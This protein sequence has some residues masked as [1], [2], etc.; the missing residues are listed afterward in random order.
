MFANRFPYTDFN[1]VNLDWIMR[2]L[3][4]QISGL[5]ASVNGMTGDVTLTASDVGALPAD[6]ANMVNSVNGETGDVE[7]TAYDITDSRFIHTS[8]MREEYA[9][10]IA[11]T[12]V[13]YLVNMADGTS[14]CVVGSPTKDNPFI[15]IYRDSFYILPESLLTYDSL[16]NNN[17]TFGIYTDG[18]TFNPDVDGNHNTITLDGVAYPI[19][20][21]TCSSFV[22]MLCKNRAYTDSPFYELFTNPD[23]TG[24]TLADHMTEYGDNAKSPWTM[25]FMNMF[26]SWKIAENMISSGCNPQPVVHYDGG[27]VYDDF[28]ESLRDGALLFMGNETDFPNRNYGIYHVVFYFKTLDRLNQVAGTDYGCS[29]KAY[30]SGDASRGYIVHCSGSTNNTTFGMLNVLRIETLSHYLSVSTSFRKTGSVVYG[31]N[32]SANALNSSKKAKTVTG[33][34]KLVDCYIENYYDGQPADSKLAWNTIVPYRAQTG[35]GI[36]SY[37]QRSYQQPYSIGGTGVTID[38]DS[39]TTSDKDGDYVFAANTTYL[40][41]P[42]GMPT[43]SPLLFECKCHRS[44]VCVQRITTMTNST[45][46][47]YER[48]KGTTTFTAWQTIY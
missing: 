45:N 15:A 20:Y 27:A 16:V 17:V 14:D 9:N 13:S 47:C 46:H 37:F 40:N 32:P 29:V 28:F 35:Y 22:T 4:E 25:D 5:V 39:Y 11:K 36:K 24:R 6:Y 8:E 42:D 26:Y 18:G 23:A 7:L 2:K 44:G 34:M 38:F 43:A 19:V 31:C 48:S 12:A 30:D 10:A 33:N 3:K 1:K 41:A 21:F